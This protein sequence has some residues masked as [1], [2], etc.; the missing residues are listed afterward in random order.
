[1]EESLKFCCAEEKKI[2]TC[3]ANFAWFVGHPRV[4]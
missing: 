4:R 1:M 2:Y 3:K